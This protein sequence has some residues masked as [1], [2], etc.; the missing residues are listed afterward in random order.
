[1]GEKIVVGPINKGLSTDRTAFVIDNDSFPTLINAYQWRGRLKRKRG[2]SFLGRLNRYLKDTDGSG[3]ITYTIVPTPITPGVSQV[4][5]GTEIFTDADTTATASSNLKSTGSGT[6][7]LNRTTGA[8]SI[9][10]AA[11]NTP[12]YYYPGIPVLGLEDFELT[13]TQFPGSL[14]FDQH[15]A[16]KISTSSPYPI[17]SVS[18]Y[19]NPSTPNTPKTIWSDVNWNAQTYTQFGGVNFQ[20]AFWVTPD[21]NASAPTSTVGMQYKPISVVDNITG[22]PPAQARLHITAHG[23][24]E[25]DY[26]FVNEVVTTTGINFQTGYV[27]SM[28]PQNANYVDVAFPN[29]TIATNGTGGIA[30]YLTK[31]ADS[32]LDCIRWYD[33]DPTTGSAPYPPLTGNQLGWVNFCPPLSELSYSISDAPARQYYLVGAKIIFPFKDR[34]LFFG[35]II[36]TSSASSQ[37]YLQDTLIYSQNGT[38]YYTASFTG[39]I[40]PTT[41]YNPLLVPTNQTAQPSSFFEDSVGFGGFIQAGI[42]APIQTV[43]NNEDV[44]IVGLSK[45]FTRLVYTSNDV[46]PFLF[47]SI[48]SELGAA[49]TFSTITMDRG[50]IT[51]GNFGIVMTSQTNADR[52]DLQ[53][54]D[55]IFQLNYSNNGAQRVTARRDYINEWIYFTYPSN[56]VSY[57]FPNQTLQYNY[58]EQTWAIFNECFTTYG[59]FRKVTGNTWGDLGAIYGTWSEWSDPWNSGA[60]T[61]LMPEVIGGNQQGYVLS[62][63]DGTGEGTSLFIQDISTSTVTSPNHCLNNGDYIIIS[64]CQGT[65]SSQVNGRIFSV[66]GTTDNTFILNPTLASATYLGGGMITRL[67]VPQIQSKQFPAGWD[68]MK[69]TRLGPQMYLLSTTASSQI[70]LL[71]FLSM[72]SANAFNNLE[73]PQPSEIVPSVT[74]QNNALIYSTVLYTCPESTNIGLS[75]SNVNLQM[76]VPE[77]G[78]AAQIWH[79][80]N[81]SLIGDTIQI[82]FTMSDAQMRSLTTTGTPLTITG[83][84]QANPCVLTVGNS[85]SIGDLVE[86][87]DVKGMTQ[88]NGNVYIITSASS[89]SITIDVNASAFTA[90][91]S[92]GTVTQV[93]LVNQ[94]AEIVIHGFVLDITPSQSLA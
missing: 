3:D 16:Y 93:G 43:D 80:I 74:S 68:V 31:T 34:L 76:Q 41:T 52:I 24:L 79:R 58:R 92:N 89:T 75:P 33:G 39:S 91:T 1:M 90:Y 23:L 56:E 29:A 61:L 44:L 82:G 53:I 26:V 87:N 50:T 65:V 21:I 72:D 88:L 45:R 64:D 66:G 69:K 17:Y 67:Y 20:G 40:L 11:L 7:T 8:L 86:I 60:S 81:T 59:T 49:S 28:N 25:G 6:G 35:P 5:I 51:F 36:Q 14:A 83:A 2:T 63:A 57:S 42:D 27:V 55:K 73:F 32:T 54:P 37:I 70:T 47:Y 62:R 38:P 22:G 84:T 9:T 46:T 15:Y 94:T 30:Q 71:I 85:L 13:T 19:K 78:Q 12:V 48:N 4:I 10:G 18:F 77:T